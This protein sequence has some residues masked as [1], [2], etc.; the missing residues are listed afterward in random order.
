MQL[1]VR[2]LK[3]VDEHDGERSLAVVTPLGGGEGGA[4]PGGAGLAAGRPGGDHLEQPVRLCRGHAG[5]DQSLPRS[6][7]QFGHELGG[8]ER[9]DLVAVAS[10]PGQPGGQALLGGAVEAVVGAF[11]RQRVGPLLVLAGEPQGK[12]DQEGGVG[13]HVDHGGAAGRARISIRRCPPEVGS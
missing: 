6:L 1:G 12:A 4:L 7:H 10:W 5:L 13:Q 8:G 11:E 9:A 2:V 3:V